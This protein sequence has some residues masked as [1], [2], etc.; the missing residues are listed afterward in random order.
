MMGKVAALNSKVI[1][2]DVVIVDSAN[3]AH[4]VYDFL[5][6]N[7]AKKALKKIHEKYNIPVV[8]KVAEKL[9]SRRR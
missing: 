9:K 6:Y 2:Y 1:T 5:E 3:Q 7:R 4:L 8:N